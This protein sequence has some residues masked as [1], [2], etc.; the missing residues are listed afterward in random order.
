M[1]RAKLT[2]GRVGIFDGEVVVWR[3]LGEAQAMVGDIVVAFCDGETTIRRL[4]QDEDGKYLLP[5]STKQKYG[6]IRLLDQ[7]QV[8]AV[9]IDKV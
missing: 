2:D 7:S 4:A 1:N 5:E 9:V 3:T 8:Q 6:P